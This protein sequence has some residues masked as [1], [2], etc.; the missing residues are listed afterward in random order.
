M[1][2]LGDTKMHVGAIISTL[3]MF[4]TLEGYNEYTGG[5]P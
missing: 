5:I 3:G 4:S 1:A 2:T